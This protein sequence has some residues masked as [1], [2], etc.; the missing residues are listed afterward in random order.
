MV[1]NGEKLEKERE[2]TGIRTFHKKQKVTNHK[3]S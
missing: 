2:F 1:E 3:E